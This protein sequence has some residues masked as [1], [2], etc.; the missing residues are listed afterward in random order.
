[1]GIR[2]FITIISQQ[3][4]INIGPFRESCGNLGISDRQVHRGGFE[5]K[6]LAIKA[7]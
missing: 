2:I 4:Y 5:G 7:R 6:L 1:M 3:F